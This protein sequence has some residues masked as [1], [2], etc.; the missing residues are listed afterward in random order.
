MSMSYLR[1][2]LPTIV[3]IG[4]FL[5]EQAQGQQLTIQQEIASKISQSMTS[6][7]LASEQCKDAKGP[8]KQVECFDDAYINHL[9]TTDYPYMNLAYR[10]AQANEALVRELK[11]KKI[12]AEQFGVRLGANASDFAEAENNA[13][14]RDLMTLGAIGRDLEER[15]Y[16][17]DLVDAI[18]NPRPT[19]TT[20]RPSLGEIE[21]DTQ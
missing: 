15:Q 12:D 11:A 17:Q 1:L 21:C 14:N 9:R 16:R 5:S 2:A 4:L 19:H 13:V 8:D 20:C 10:Y 18:K 6:M 3:V 7:R